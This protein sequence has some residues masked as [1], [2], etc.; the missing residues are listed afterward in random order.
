MTS[1]ELDRSS[2]N[3]IRTLAIDAIQ[4]AKSGHPGTPMGMAPVAYALWQKRL[5]FDP[6]STCL[7][8][9]RPLH[10]LGGAC[11]HAALRAALPDQDAGGERELRDCGRP[12]VT[13]DDIKSFPA[14]RQRLPRPSRI[15]SDIRRRGDDRAARPGCRDERR[16]GDG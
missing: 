8:E 14:A 1:S 2:I 5:I 16:P 3:T 9:P 4:K 15:P 12:S 6:A 13:L 7:A 11:L 10:P